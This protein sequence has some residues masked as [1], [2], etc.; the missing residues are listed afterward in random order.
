MAKSFE[1]LEADQFWQGTSSRFRG[2]L[3]PTIL[4]RSRAGLDEFAFGCH[5]EQ[6]GQ[7]PR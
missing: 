2:R 6:P 3:A 4:T 7:L 5:V 1:V